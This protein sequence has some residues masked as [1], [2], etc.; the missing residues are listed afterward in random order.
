M[1]NTDSKELLRISE[2]Q[3]TVTKFIIENEI[4]KNT[5]WWSSSQAIYKPYFPVAPEFAHEK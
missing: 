2:V 4:K 5:V 1:C 3:S